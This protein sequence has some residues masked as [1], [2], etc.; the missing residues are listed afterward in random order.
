M[1]IVARG[2][3]SPLRQLC[4]YSVI[5][6]SANS[7]GLYRA[8]TIGSVILPPQLSGRQRFQRRH[9]LGVSGA[10]GA[11]VPLARRHSHSRPLLS[12]LAA[13]RVESKF[14]AQR[15]RASKS[16]TLNNSC[17]K[18][19]GRCIRRSAICVST[20]RSRNQVRGDLKYE[21][22]K[23]LAQLHCRGVAFG[24]CGH[25]VL[26]A[27]TSRTASWNPR[28]ASTRF[29]TSSTISLG[30]CCHQIYI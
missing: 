21:A 15:T 10:V 9:L 27:R 18:L 7:M 1:R 12:K 20:R 23:V 11:F 29:C 26:A 22:N 25:S 13:P 8:R 4:H 24:R 28:P 16:R 30:S 14:A 2:T 19:T 3:S 6:Q 5:R 17:A